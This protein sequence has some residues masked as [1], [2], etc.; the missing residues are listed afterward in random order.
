[1]SH[2]L[3]SLYLYQEQS[4]ERKR[5]NSYKRDKRDD[6]TEIFTGLKLGVRICYRLLT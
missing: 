6:I 4:S 2:N 5:D 3:K 1:M